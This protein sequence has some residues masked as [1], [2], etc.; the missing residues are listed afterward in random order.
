MRIKR[1]IS[2]FID[3]MISLYIM[4]PNLFLNIVNIK[5][6]G[7]IILVSFSMKDLIFKN[8]SIGKKI[9][10]LEIVNKEN[11]KPNKLILICRNL[12]VFIWPLEIIL[13][14]IFNKRIGDILFNTQVVEVKNNIKQEQSQQ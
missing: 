11:E 4:T 12:T 9:M 10:K 13:L 6:E 14:L 7:I 5:W 8:Q 3:Y 1:L 2:I